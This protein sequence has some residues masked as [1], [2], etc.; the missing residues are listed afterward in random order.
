MWILAGR[1]GVEIFVV[2]AQFKRVVNNCKGGDP[3]SSE[4][5]ALEAQALRI[6]SVGVT[7]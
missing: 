3:M 2:E 5:N 1:E 4:F 6:N 7:A